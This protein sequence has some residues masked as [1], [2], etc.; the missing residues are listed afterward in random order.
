MKRARSRVKCQAGEILSCDE[1]L[2]LKLRQ[3]HSYAVAEGGGS[4]GRAWQGRG[5][6]DISSEG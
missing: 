2:M 3:L 6:N 4:I 5:M 1:V